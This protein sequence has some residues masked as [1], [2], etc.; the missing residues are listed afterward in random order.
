MLDEYLDEFMDLLLALVWFFIEVQY[1]LIKVVLC[2]MYL[3]E[4][5]ELA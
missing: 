1:K 3:L 4:L 5:H 2:R